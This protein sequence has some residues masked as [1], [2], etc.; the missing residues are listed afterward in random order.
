ME[1]KCEEVCPEGYFG[2]QCV[3]PCNCKRNSNFVCHP[4]NGCICKAGF[5]GT[6]CDQRLVEGQVQELPGKLIIIYF[7]FKVRIKNYLNPTQFY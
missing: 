2:L 4:I 5:G 6:N 3:Q 7:I 1:P